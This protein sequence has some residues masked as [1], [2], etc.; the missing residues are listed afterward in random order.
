MRQT[1][2]AVQDR[3][4]LPLEVEVEEGRCWTEISRGE[5]VAVGMSPQ[6]TNF[7]ITSLN[8]KVRW[9]PEDHR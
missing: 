9:S 3:V 7:L 1:F 6:L 2:G 5:A 8:D 4:G